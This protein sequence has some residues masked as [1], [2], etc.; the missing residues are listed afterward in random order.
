MKRFF[1][2]VLILVMPWIAACSDATVESCHL[3][4]SHVDDKGLAGQ[5]DGMGSVY[6]HYKNASSSIHVNDYITV[7]YR[8]DR[9][10][11]EKGIIHFR[12]GQTF[13]CDWIIE[14]VDTLTVQ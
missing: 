6:I 1:A 11:Q 13:S 12:S 9:I 4:V 10:T 3:Y 2:L 5:I 14:K 7:S 8:S